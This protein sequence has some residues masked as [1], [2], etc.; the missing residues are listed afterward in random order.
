M[1][2]DPPS[3]SPPPREGLNIM[4]RTSFQKEFH[5]NCF[6]AGSCQDSLPRLQQLPAVLEETVFC[7]CSAVHSYNL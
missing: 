3:L 7:L 1:R 4:I 5:I 6:R 2:Y